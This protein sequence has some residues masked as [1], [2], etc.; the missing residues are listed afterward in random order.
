MQDLNIGCQEYVINTFKNPIAIL[1]I[2]VLVL[3]T[4]GWLFIDGAYYAYDSPYAE[5]CWKLATLSDTF[6]TVDCI[7][8]LNENSGM[9]GQQVIDHF[10]NIS[11]DQIP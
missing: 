9:T 7:K 2:S 1:L 5:D 3:G 11:L 6:S 10:E 8:Y 4:I